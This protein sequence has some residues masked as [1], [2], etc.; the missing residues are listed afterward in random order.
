[1]SEILSNFNENEFKTY[2]LLYAVNADFKMQEE[3]KEIILS[4][5]SV[6]DFKHILKVFEQHSDFVRIET[7][8]SYRE[9]YFPTEKDVENL[10][11]S[12][13]ELLYADDKFNLNEKNFLRLITKLLNK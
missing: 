3:E 12:I 10:L 9:K 11:K 6:A 8:L 1:M 13:T 5:V 4:K 7:I 2:L